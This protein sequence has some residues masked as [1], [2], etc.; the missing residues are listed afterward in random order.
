MTRFL[1][2]NEAFALRDKN[3]EE[4][5]VNGKLRECDGKRVKGHQKRRVAMK[6]NGDDA[7]EECCN[8]QTHRWPNKKKEENWKTCFTKRVR[9]ENQESPKRCMVSG[10]LCLT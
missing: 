5:E 9:N 4:N 10:F 6:Q 8:K 3:R 7:P 1:F 2:A